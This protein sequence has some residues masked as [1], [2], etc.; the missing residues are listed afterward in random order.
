MSKITLNFFGEIFSIE[1]ANDLS[2]L[3][4]EISTLLCLNP[5]DAAEIIL[6]YKDNENEDKKII[7]NDNDLNAFF[8]SKAKIIDLD[9]S[10]SSQIYK[11]NLD[12]LQEEK[13][14]DKDDLEELLKKNDELEK[15]K[16]TKLMQEKQELQSIN[17]QINELFKRREELNNIILTETNQ[18]VQ[19]QIENDKKI[20]TLQKK[21]GI[22]VTVPKRDVRNPLFS[23]F[24][25][26]FNFGFHPHAFP[27]F[28]NPGF[29]GRHHRPR[30]QFGGNSYIG[31][32]KNHNAPEP[33]NKDDP[34]KLSEKLKNLT[35]NEE[36]PKEDIK[37]DEKD[38]NEKRENK[39]I[40]YNVICDG[41]QA[42]PIEGKRYKC[43]TC[44][45][46]DYCEKCYEA[47][48]N[49][50]N[51]EFLVMEKPDNENIYMSNLNLSV[52]G[53]NN[54]YNQF[55]N[56][57]LKRRRIENNS[58]N[59]NFRNIHFGVACNG[60]GVSPILGCRYKC[61]VCDDYDLCEECEKKMAEEHGHN[62]LK[63]Y[64]SKK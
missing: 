50:H 7:S 31:H 46:F 36:D 26:M 15:L 25:N 17:L 64:E 43:K 16:E 63:L 62:F 55:H 59:S 37:E 6:T 56:N 21:L 19:E 48:K 27:H 38:K 33:Y 42:S 1:K 24:E 29:H 12:Q 8:N 47:F 28:F 35:L 11:K 57:N 2:S 45:D 13:Q 32:K 22:P 52:N 61:S 14:K 9:I 39:V 60:C 40:H 10:Q 49:S 18:I 34:N 3:R 23:Q 30:R 20:E 58:T 53:Y 44:G 51:H 54:F 4:N 5:Q 41:C